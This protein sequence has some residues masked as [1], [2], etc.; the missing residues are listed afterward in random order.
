MECD[1]D[2]NFDNVDWYL[3]FV[4]PE[5]SNGED[6]AWKC[7]MLFTHNLEQVSFTPQ[8]QGILIP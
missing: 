5:V 3:I 6:A 1:F 7:F 8:R 2:D 4:N